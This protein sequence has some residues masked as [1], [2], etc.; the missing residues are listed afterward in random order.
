MK[1]YPISKFEAIKEARRLIRMGIPFTI[2]VNYSDSLIPV[3][4]NSVGEF[5]KSRAYML[6]GKEHLIIGK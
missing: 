4:D 2:T 1:I 6:E 3:D 5:V